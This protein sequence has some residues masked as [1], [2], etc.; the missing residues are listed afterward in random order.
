MA[1]WLFGGDET[2]FERFFPDLNFRFS[3]ERKKRMDELLLRQNSQ[4]IRL[5]FERINRAMQFDS[6]RS[7]LDLGVV[8]GRDC[9]ET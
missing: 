7:M 9:V 6:A 3:P 8:P 4:H 2:A 1:I 5:I